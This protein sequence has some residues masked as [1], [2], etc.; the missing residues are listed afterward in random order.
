MDIGVTINHATSLL[1]RFECRH[2]MRVVSYL[3]LCI[4][5]FMLF[6]IDRQNHLILNS[7]LN[8]EKPLLTQRSHNEIVYKN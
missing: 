5:I 3:K 4:P 7:I 2:M 1:I 8:R 6:R